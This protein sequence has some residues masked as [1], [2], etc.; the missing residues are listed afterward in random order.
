MN[1]IW[2]VSDTFR[3][4]HVGAYGNRWIH[5]PSIDALAASSVRFDSHY[6]AGFPYYA[7]A[8]GSPDRTLDDVIHGMATTS[9]RCYHA[10]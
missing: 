3:R 1:V 10:R 5:T 4:D 6:S 7:H 2:I 8:S 9:C